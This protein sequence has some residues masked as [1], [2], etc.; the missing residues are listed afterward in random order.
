MSRLIGRVTVWPRLK[1]G[2]SIQV[3][4]PR[5]IPGDGSQEHRPAYVSDSRGVQVGDHN[6]QQFIETYVGEAARSPIHDPAVVGNVPQK[7]PAFQARQELLEQLAMSGPGV[8]VVRGSHGDARRRQDP[9]GGSAGAGLHRRRLE[10]GFLGR[11]RQP[12]SD[13]GRPGR[14]RRDVGNQPAGQAPTPNVN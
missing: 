11:F 9:V 14:H 7:A 1:R 13:P 6:V 10:A 8:T 5:M 3:R 4:V 2:M 12:G